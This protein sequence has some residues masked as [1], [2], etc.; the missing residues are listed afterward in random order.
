LVGIATFGLVKGGGAAIQA[1]KG[2]KTIDASQILFSQNSVN[3]LA[4]KVQG[5]R[6]RGWAGAPIDVVATD[7]GL[8]AV[9]NTRLLAAHITDT[10]VK[11]MIRG[12]NELVPAGRFTQGPEALAKTWGEAVAA[13][14]GKQTGGYPELFPSGSWFTGVNKP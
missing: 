10:P 9:D 2:V 6:L 11:A 4:E 12:A 8:V 14:I 7:A 13:R 3:N 5:M 1:L